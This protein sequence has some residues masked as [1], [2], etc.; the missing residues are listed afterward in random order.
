ML[1]R[2]GRPWPFA[3]TRKKPGLGPWGLSRCYRGLSHLRPE[4][5][6]KHILVVVG[7]CEPHPNDVVQSKSYLLL[8]FFCSLS[9]LKIL[10]SP[11]EF[12]P[13]WC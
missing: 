3:P 12:R 11:L 4:R 1:A 9:Y 13:H 2:G 7:G 6:L 5:V 10:Q 8:F